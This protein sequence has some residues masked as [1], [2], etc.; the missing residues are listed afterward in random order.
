MRLRLFFLLWRE[1]SPRSHTHE[2]T[3]HL[4]KPGAS[5]DEKAGDR[6][7]GIRMNGQKIFMLYHQ[8]LNVLPILFW[9]KI[10]IGNIKA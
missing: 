5:M 2:G 10:P 4:T 9:E 1:D 8:V 6:L 7:P 3:P